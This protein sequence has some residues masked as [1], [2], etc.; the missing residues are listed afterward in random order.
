[1]AHLL[2]LDHERRG[3]HGKFGLPTRRSIAAS[4]ANS[5]HGNGPQA[6]HSRRKHKGRRL[7]VPVPLEAADERLT[8]RD[9]ALRRSPSYAPRVSSTAREVATYEDVLAAPEHVIAKVVDGPLRLRPRPASR[10]ARVVSSLGFEIMG[11]LD[12]GRGGPGGWVILDEP[13]LHLGP[14]PSIVVPDLAGWRV[15]RADFDGDG[16][17]VTIVPD[18]I[19]EVLSPA[20][21]PFDRSRKADL[22]AALGVDDLWLIDASARQIETFRSA[23]GKWLRLGEFDQ[24]DARVEPFDAVLLDVPTLFTFPNER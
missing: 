16:A 13:E 9:K 4:E 14:D 6:G 8:T 18:R 17:F 12:R 23:Q 5:S 24:P 21:A 2:S 3:L 22:Y 19:C 7:T 1:M 15:A 10:H 20:T 11:P